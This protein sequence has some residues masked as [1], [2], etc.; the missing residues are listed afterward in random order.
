MSIQGSINQLLAMAGT[1]AMLSPS[2]RAKA[3]DRRE[4]A[5]LSRREQSLMLQREAEGEAV[6]GLSDAE[7][8]AKETDPVKKKEAEIEEKLAKQTDVEL[9]DIAERQFQLNP[10]QES[11]AKATKARSHAEMPTVSE[12]M[13]SQLQAQQERIAAM[14]QASLDNAQ[15]QA[16]PKQQRRSFKNVQVDFGDGSRG[17]VGELPKSWQKQISEQLKPEQRKKLIAQTEPK[18]NK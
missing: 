9:A 5:N 18:E 14:S 8:E 12:V 15:E 7:L 11:L 4:A 6:S 17:T 1:A 13:Q 2:L 3:E 16:R 10:S